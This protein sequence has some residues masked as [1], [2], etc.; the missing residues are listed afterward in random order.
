KVDA[1]TKAFNEAESAISRANSSIADYSKNGLENIRDK[2]GEVTSAVLNLVAAL[3]ELDSKAAQ[4]K[5]I[6]LWT[7][8]LMIFW[9]VTMR[10]LSWIS[11]L[12]SIR[13]FNIALRS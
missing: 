1:F 4:T 6:R 10:L 7:L 3:A 13:L 2:Y 11:S 5:L 12:R 9:V 8:S